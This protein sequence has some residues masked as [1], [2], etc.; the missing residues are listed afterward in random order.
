MRLPWFSRISGKE[1]VECPISEL[2]VQTSSFFDLGNRIPYGKE[3]LGRESTH[4]SFL[5][6]LS[7]TVGSDVGRYARSVLCAHFERK[8]A[9]KHCPQFMSNINRK[10]NVSTNFDETSK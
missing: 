4:H 10:K 1:T 3:A 8:L 6:V 2:H 9:L 5:Q 7:I